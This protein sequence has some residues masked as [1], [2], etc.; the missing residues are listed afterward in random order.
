MAAVA[1]GVLVIYVLRLDHIAGM[2]VDDAWY[3]LLGRALA[4][5]EGYSLV[6][7]PIPGILPPNPPGFAAI[8]SLV[9]RAAPS[10]PENVLL[11]KAVS[12]AAMM[13]VGACSYWYFAYG[14]ELPRQL[15]FGLAVAITITP[16]FVFLATSSVM[17]ECVFTLIMLLAV[18]FADRSVA[19]AAVAT[20]RD[21]VIAATLSAAAVL[22]RTAG[23]PVPVALTLYLLTQRRWRQTALFVAIVSLCVAP[24]VWYS[25]AH[26]PT[27]EQRV[28]HGGV[29]AFTYGDEFW[30]RLAGAP[31]M[32][33]IMP[34]QLPARALAGLIDV[35]GRDIAG[36]VVPTLFRGADES[37]EEVIALGGG[38]FHA[39]MGGVGGTMV[40]SFVL[41]AVL[42]VGFITA[43]R[44]GRGAT[45]AEFVVPFS[46]AMIVLWPQWAYRF[47]LPLTPYVFFY[48]I[49]GLRRLTMS[50]PVA[51]IALGCVI[52]LNLMDHT[53]YIIRSQS[54]VMD[55]ATDAEEVD[56]VL[57]WMEQH[58]PKDAD[59]AT[60]NPALVFLRTG[61]RTMS[62]DDTERNWQNFQRRGIHYIVC[63]H[64][65]SLPL[66]HRYTL[67]YRSPKERLWVVAN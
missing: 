51:R 34:W 2:V 14:R 11:L 12:V 16:G 10:F 4:R 53:Q 48:L 32:G 58:V 23:I 30:M 44:R 43:A 28:A 52:G 63:L 22:I 15:A 18:I 57:A 17:S 39:S 65:S 6:N 21:T 49:T 54:E 1:A 8:L 38:M 20:R 67:L 64:P 55:W 27:M 24:W 56:S 19:K 26:A 9:F 47:V 66:F 45:A 60:S 61:R 31:T 3:I 5:G 35:F 40:L 7:S 36:L 50:M 59:V 42:I 62:L 37:G 46:I 29:H 13:G 41:S 25:H 33:W